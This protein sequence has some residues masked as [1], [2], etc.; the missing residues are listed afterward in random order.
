M[1]GHGKKPK[2]P[3]PNGDS[4]SEGVGADAEMLGVDPSGG[5]T[6]G[7]GLDAKVLVLNKLYMG[8]R[9]IPA[10]RA[11]SLLAGRIRI[12]TRN[13]HSPGCGRRS[14]SILFSMQR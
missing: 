9:V 2:H 3:K 7:L 10:R 14:P 13:L 12:P 1:A 5:V 11:F 6:S 8:I 4:L